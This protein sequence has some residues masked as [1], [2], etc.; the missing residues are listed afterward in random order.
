MNRCFVGRVSYLT[1]NP[2]PVQTRVEKTMIKILVVGKNLKRARV[3]VTAPR[4]E[5]V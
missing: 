3:A 1:G 4:R 5:P 2:K